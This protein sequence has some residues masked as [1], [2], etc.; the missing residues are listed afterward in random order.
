MTAITD[1]Q[2][3]Q[4]DFIQFKA[5]N[6]NPESMAEAN[7]ALV[8]RLNGVVEVAREMQELLEYHLQDDLRRECG[9]TQ[10]RR[11]IARAKEVLR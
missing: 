8:R 9:F 6:E 10:E 4:I 2:R 3:D 5:L 7:Q 11:V 1:H